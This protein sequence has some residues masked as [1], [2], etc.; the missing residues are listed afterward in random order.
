MQARTATSGLVLERRVRH[1]PGV[2]TRIVVLVALAA[3]LAA[4]AVVAVAATSANGLPAYTNGY[5]SWPRLNAKPIR[6][7]SS[8]HRGVK[9][10]YAS[11]KR[12]GKLFP[13]GTVIVKS[14]A[15]PGDRAARPSQVA[16]MRKVAGRW[17]W[18]EYELSGSRYTVLAQGALCVSCHVQA[19]ARD[20]VFTKR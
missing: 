15:Q 12:V 4:A 17:R 13:N 20:W 18:V 5:Q 8:A 7:G 1:D 10:V 19:R 9:N 6:G 11:R 14:I 3:L 16:V 2:R